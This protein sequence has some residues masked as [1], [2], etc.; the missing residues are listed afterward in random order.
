MVGPLSRLQLAQQKLC[1]CQLSVSQALL[2]VASVYER[3]KWNLSAPINV[4]DTA[5]TNLKIDEAQTKPVQA[6]QNVAE[7]TYRQSLNKSKFRQI[8]ER[9]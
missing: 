9:G 1:Y 4:S 5:R 8:A 7:P 6:T 2:S 3:T